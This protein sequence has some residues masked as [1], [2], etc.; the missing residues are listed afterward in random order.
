VSQPFGNQPTTPLPGEPAPVGGPA[1]G[2]F[3]QQ[4]YAPPPRKSN[5]WVWLLGGCGCSAIL[6]V[7][8]CGGLAY[9]GA[10]KGGQMLGK[11]LEGPLREQ[12]ADNADVKEH[13]GEIESLTA[14]FMASGQ[15][16][17]ARGGGNWLVMDA[18]GSKGNGTFIVETVPGAQGSDAFKHIEL[19]TEEGKTFQIK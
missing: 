18:E 15:E 16:Q 9:F 7:L 13:L 2:P 5:W 14:D 8:C 1:P 4:P 12:V 10:T 3:A 19:R 11:V 6:L 17:K